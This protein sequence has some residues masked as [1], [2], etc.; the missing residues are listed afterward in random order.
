VRSQ[1][2]WLLTE[3][4]QVKVKVKVK[5]LR[6]LVSECQESGMYVKKARAGNQQKQRRGF[7]V[8]SELPSLPSAGSRSG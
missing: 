1:F 3:L 4:S 5:S 8:F 6:I 2:E 7:L